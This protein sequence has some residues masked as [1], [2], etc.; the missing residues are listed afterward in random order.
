MSIGG[1]HNTSVT[2]PDALARSFTVLCVVHMGP[3]K[4]ASQHYDDGLPIRTG[5][6]AGSHVSSCVLCLLLDSM[7][8][9]LSA[10]LPQA[11]LQIHTVDVSS[12]RHKDCP[13]Y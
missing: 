6:Q 3:L 12:A 13:D 5:S 1:G 10:E 7:W 8:S 9:P 11:Q 4:S 2:V